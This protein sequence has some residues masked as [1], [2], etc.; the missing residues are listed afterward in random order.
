MFCPMMAA[1]ASVFVQKGTSVYVRA[2]EL[3][4]HKIFLG[5]DFVIWVFLGK[6][7]Y[8]NR[9]GILAVFSGGTSGLF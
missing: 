9:G 5:S 4:G 1:K 2:L 7:R 3:R 8:D 6:I